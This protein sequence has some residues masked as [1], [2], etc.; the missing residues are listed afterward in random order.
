MLLPHAPQPG[1][2]TENQAEI[3]GGFLAEALNYSLI[4]QQTIGLLIANK[5]RAIKEEFR[6]GLERL[7]R[8]IDSE[9]A[10]TTTENL[11]VDGS[12]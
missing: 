4:P 9:Y 7:A 1:T 6:Q 5:P 10:T 2:I 12:V 11:E 3:L 8:V